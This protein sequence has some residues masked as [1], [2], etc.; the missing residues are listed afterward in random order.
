MGRDNVSLS[1]AEM[2]RLLADCYPGVQWIDGCFIDRIIIPPRFMRQLS[3]DR[4]AQSPMAAAYEALIGA[5]RSGKGDNVIYEKYKAITGPSRDDRPGTSVLGLM[6]GKYGIF[7]DLMI[8]KRVEECGRAV[9]VADDNIHP[10]EVLVPRAMTKYIRVT[11]PVTAANVA[12]VRRLASLGMITDARGNAVAPTTIRV[13]RRYM[14]ALADG[15]TVMLNRQPTL[16]RNSLMAMRVRVSRD[17]N[18]KVIAIN[19]AATPSFN[20]DFD[21]DEMNVFFHDDIASMTETRCLMAASKN[22]IAPGTSRPVINPVQDTVTCLYMITSREAGVSRQQYMQC[23]VHCDGYVHRGRDSYTTLDLVSLCIPRGFNYAMDDVEISDGVLVRGTINKRVLS[24]GDE[25]II[26]VMTLTRGGDVSMA[27]VSKLQRLSSWVSVSMGMGLSFA[28]MYSSD[29]RDTSAG[30]MATMA[31]KKW[32]SRAHALA[33]SSACRNASEKQAKS[34]LGDGGNVMCAMI[35]SG[36]KGNVTNLAQIRVMVGQQLVMGRMPHRGSGPSQ[37]CDMVQGLRRCGFCVS[38][39]IK[40]LSPTEYMFHQMAGRE[41][42]VRVNIST[43]VS[44]YQSRRLTKPL[45]CVSV[46]YNNAVYSTRTVGNNSNVGNRL[47][48]IQHGMASMDSSLCLPGDVVVT[49][50]ILDNI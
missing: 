14:R 37:D 44:G 23:F 34:W 10:D 39:Y 24:S 2:S 22:I 5:I 13:K 18:S 20:A 17:S 31:H 42:V 32:G 12:H 9:I 49:G 48:R 8:G 28:D 29:D 43:S 45:S 47:I 38:S 40:G 1:F 11:V 16:T 6:S 27:F 30:I 3:D 15:D 35:A 21:G 41:G 4:K 26:S 33:A 7:R 46:G 36:S 50:N 25:S 19:T